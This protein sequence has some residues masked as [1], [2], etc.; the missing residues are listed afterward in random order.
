MSKSLCSYWIFNREGGE[1]RMRNFTSQAEFTQA[2]RA[3]L[4]RSFDTKPEPSPTTGTIDLPLWQVADGTARWAI[5]RKGAALL[6]ASEA[7]NA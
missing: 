7:S 1:I 6:F 2:R 3:S 5:T 4:A